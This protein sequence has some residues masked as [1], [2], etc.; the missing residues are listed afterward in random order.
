MAYDAILFGNG[1]TLCY[2]NQMKSKIPGQYYHCL[3]I[4]N[5]ID[6]FLEDRL[7]VREENKLRKMFKEG[8]KYSYSF[9]QQE[10]SNFRKSFGVN[11]EWIWGK[12]L[13]SPSDFKKHKTVLD[14]M[15]ILFNLWYSNLKTLIEDRL[16]LGN[17]ANTFACSL[18]KYLTNSARI[19][20]TNFDGFLDSLNPE[21]IHGQFVNDCSCYK[22]LCWYKTSYSTFFF[23]FIWAPSEVGKMRMI[24]Q[25]THIE[26]HERYFNFSFFHNSV[27][28]ENMLVFGLSFAKAGYMEGLETFDSK[29]MKN[30]FGSCIDD[31]ILTRLKV[32][33]EKKEV[34][35]I[36]FAY[37]READRRHYERLISDYGLVNSRVL[38]SSSFDLRIE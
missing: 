29:Y 24:E 19:I 23:P 9:V 36:T 13:T 27:N 12:L 37:Y 3:F 33:Q 10:L 5:F 20:T 34:G 38:P 32:L 7:T 2:Q 4:E 1:L 28:A 31:H 14:C 25:I 22:D 18:Q 35:S 6:A 11:Y 15:P 17:T 26:G 21:H 30:S 16:E 8:Y